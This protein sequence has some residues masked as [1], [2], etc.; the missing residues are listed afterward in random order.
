MLS[1]LHKKSGVTNYNLNR[2]VAVVKKQSVLVVVVLRDVISFFE[3]DTNIRRGEILY[4]AGKYCLS[5]VMKMFQTI[6]PKYILRRL[7]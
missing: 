3:P 5:I 7:V 6:V 1:L 4:P 2:K